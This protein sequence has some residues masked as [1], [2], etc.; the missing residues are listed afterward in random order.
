MF[1]NYEILQTQKI[2]N[3]RNLI[4]Q[5]SDL[6]LFCEFFVPVNNFLPVEFI[7]GKSV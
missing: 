6:K 7:S 2:D 5:R 1:N 4:Y 3:V